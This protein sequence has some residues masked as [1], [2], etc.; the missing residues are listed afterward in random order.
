MSFIR[1]KSNYGLL[2]FYWLTYIGL[3]T[4]TK[5]ETVKYLEI[6]DQNKIWL[7]KTGLLELSPRIYII[8][9]FLIISM[10]SSWGVFSDGAR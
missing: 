1:D 3:F 6:N 10:D 7:I 5:I 9:C 4:N 8:F 2:I